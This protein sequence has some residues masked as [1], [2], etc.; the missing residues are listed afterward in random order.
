MDG[1]NWGA[2]FSMAIVVIPLAAFTFMLVCI[3]IYSSQ[4]GEQEVTL[5]L[6]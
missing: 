3:G 2:W 5:P 6:N 4:E 1:M